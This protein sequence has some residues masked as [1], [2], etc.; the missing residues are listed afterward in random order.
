MGQV[1]VRVHA[2]R[3]LEQKALRQL[4]LHGEAQRVHDCQQRLVHLPP[5][6]RAPD[7]RHHQVIHDGVVI[8][9][10]GE[11]LQ[12]ACLGGLVHAPVPEV[13]CGV[14]D[15]PDEVAVAPD[16]VRGRSGLAADDGCIG[17]GC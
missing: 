3:Q 10:V 7:Q 12:H 8:H 2:L 17:D 1:D 13:V 11:V 16:L 6:L 5:Q 14:S 4:R 15:P 9:D